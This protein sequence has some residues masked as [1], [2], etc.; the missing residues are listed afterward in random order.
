MLILET[1]PR[2]VVKMQ[3]AVPKVDIDCFDGNLLNC[4]YFMA[5]LCDV[6]ETRIENPWR[7]LTMLIKYTV[8]EA[9]EL[10]TACSY[11]MIRVIHNAESLL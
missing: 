8:G 9:N 10:N 7:R 11:L 2:K 1:E 3:Q 6:V 4:H 5:L